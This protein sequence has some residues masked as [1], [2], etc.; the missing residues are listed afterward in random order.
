[1]KLSVT[2]TLFALLASCTGCESTP[3]PVKIPAVPAPE[4]K[5]AEPVI[6]FAVG[7]KVSLDTGAKVIDGIILAVGPIGVWQNTKTGEKRV[8]R[9]YQ[10]RLSVPGKMW[11]GILPEFALVKRS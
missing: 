9:A 8:S 3:T 4:T 5:P 1:M 6:K 2:L 10:V 11:I 7:D